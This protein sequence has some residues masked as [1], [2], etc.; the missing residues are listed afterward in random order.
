MPPS[1]PKR[2]YVTVSPDS[3]GFEDR[4]WAGGANIGWFELSARL[5]Q[6]R[7]LLADELQEISLAIDYASTLPEVDASRVGFIGHSFGGRMAMWAPAWDERFT[8]S[9]SNC[10][11]ITYRHSS[12][13]DA[14][15][16]ADFVV[17]G[18]AANFDVE[19]VLALSPGC[20]TLVIAAQADVWSRGYVEIDVR[21]K[22]LGAGH[23]SVHAV[24]GDHRFR[25]AEREFA[26]TFLSDRLRP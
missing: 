18:F 15:F 25:A 5:V 11:C 1:W 8:V 12:S 22:E 19:D 7:T 14:G 26:Y 6:G 9:V 20:E 24:S 2:G 10:G 13:R 3:I 16:Q 17:P 21:L 4:N 23:V